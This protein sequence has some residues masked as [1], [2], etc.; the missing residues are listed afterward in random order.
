MESAHYLHN[1]SIHL[2][3]LIID[4]NLKKYKRQVNIPWYTTRE[5]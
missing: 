5:R 1:M 2:Y 3:F 4:M